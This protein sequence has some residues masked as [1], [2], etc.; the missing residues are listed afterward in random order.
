MP[1]KSNTNKDTEYLYILISKEMGR[2]G[3]PTHNDKIHSVYKSQKDA[4]V[5]INAHK[6]KGQS[7]WGFEISQTEVFEILEIPREI[8]FG[9]LLPSWKE[10]MERMEDMLSELMESVPETEN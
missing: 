7:N 5:M 3:T 2:D 9:Q 6:E 10:D 1:K 4:E 8:T